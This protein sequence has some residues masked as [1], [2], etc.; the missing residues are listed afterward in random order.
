MARAGINLTST[1]G[2]PIPLHGAHP[3]MAPTTM[4]GDRQGDDR[5]K[6]VDTVCQDKRAHHASELLGSP[7]AVYRQDAQHDVGTWAVIENWHNPV[8]V[9]MD[10]IEV[11]ERRFEGAGRGLR[12]HDRRRASYKKLLSFSRRVHGVLRGHCSSGK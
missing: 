1:A 9:T 4:G 3:A 8:P 2:L 7:L 10:E 12:P 11:F 6:N 5:S